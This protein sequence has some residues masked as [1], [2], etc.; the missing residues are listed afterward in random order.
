MKS[1]SWSSYQSALPIEARAGGE[2]DDDPRTPEDKRADAETEEDRRIREEAEATT[3]LLTVCKTPIPSG[4]PGGTFADDLFT[5]AG[6][7]EETRY[8][9]VAGR[10]R[11]KAK[12]MAA[13]IAK[14]L[15][16]TSDEPKSQAFQAGYERAENQFYESELS[17]FSF[18]GFMNPFEEGTDEFAGFEKGVENLSK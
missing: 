10:L 14:T 12:A 4:L 11:E 15:A 16:D 13:A 5:I 2:P 17:G 1:G 7:L 8:S 3:D 6:M 9:D 18:I